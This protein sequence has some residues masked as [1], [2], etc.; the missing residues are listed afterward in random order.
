MQRNGQLDD[1]EIGA[2]VSA[3]PGQTSDHLLPDLFGQLQQL[4][5]RQSLDVSWTLYQFEILAHG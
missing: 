1:A 5:R 2:Q 4:V 3:V